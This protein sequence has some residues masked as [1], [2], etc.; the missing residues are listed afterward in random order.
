MNQ[1]T[2]FR[3]HRDIWIFLGLLAVSSFVFFSFI[4]IT[5][6]VDNAF[7]FSVD[8]P[9][10]QNESLISSKFQRKDTQVIINAVGEISSA[11]YF[12]KIKQL[13][14]ALMRIPGVTAVKSIAAGPANLKDARES[15][16]WKRILIADKEESTNVI[17]LIKEDFI[18]TIIPGIENVV[19]IMQNGDFHLHLSGIPYIVVLIQRNL[20][21]DLRIFSL[22]AIAIFGMVITLT[23][24]SLRILLGTMTACISACI[25]TFMIT[26]LFKVNIGILTANLVTIVFVLTL[27]HIIFITFNWKALCKDCQGANPIQEAMR[28]TFWASFWSM[29][30][31][32]LGF[33]SL[34][35]VEAKPL[36]ELGV[37]GTIGTLIGIL[38]AYGVYP[39]FLRSKTSPLPKSNIVVK[40]EFRFYRFLDKRKR[41]LAFGVFAVCLAGI[42]GLF[43]LNTDPSMISYFASDSSIA[44]GLKAIDR[45]GGSNPM[46]A[47]VKLQSGE[48]LVTNQA[49]DRLWSLQKAL[50]SHEEV[51]A[52]ISLPVL[53]AQAKRAPLAFFLRWDWLLKILEWPRFNEVAKS[54]ISNDHSSGLF[55]L[56]MKELNRKKLRLQVVEEI[57]TLITRQGF[58]PEILGGVYVL[59]GHMSQLVTSSLVFGLTRLIILFFII[60]WILSRSLRM[61]GAMMVSVCLIPLG[62]MGVIG[63]LGIPLDIIAA[64]AANVAIAMG[65]DSMIHMVKTY[66]RRKPDSG[67]DEETWRWVRLRLWQPILTSMLVICLGFSIFLFSQFPPT[68]RFGGIIF[69]STILA[70]FIALF[71]M[72][73]LAGITFRRSGRA[74]KKSS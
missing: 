17:V 41:L 14:D 28:I 25:W 68:R 27:S 57:K 67:S 46:I 1:S 4:D 52:V 22:L 45:N 58:I 35:A 59:Q 29:L 11:G 8:D 34:L 43:M 66:R 15:P 64:P 49:Y 18:H 65:I 71:M 26:A 16:L 73:L 53:M 3:F 70:A 10:F 7:F 24:R 32:L 51:G 9:Q 40:E 54:F 48:K 38:A 36:R 2:T 21:K 44:E 6:K 31:T 42:P 13:S 56:R 50:E 61:A 63:L 60:S 37:S 62:T 5:P 39:A 19:E 33:I 30:T 12:K 69:F 74:P 72:P 23:F 55:L 47:V 20:T